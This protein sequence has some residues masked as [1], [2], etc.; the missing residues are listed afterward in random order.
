MVW[1]ETYLE[2]YTCR[3]RLPFKKHITWTMYSPDSFLWSFLTVNVSRDL[4]HP[5]MK[6]WANNSFPDEKNVSLQKFQEEYIVKLHKTNIFSAP[7]FSFLVL[8]L[9]LLFLGWS[10]NLSHWERDG[11]PAVKKQFR[12][13]PMCYFNKL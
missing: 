5:M 10:G 11:S 3:S 12:G 8:L 2:S 13:H 6:G 7:T 9:H 1:D 4:H